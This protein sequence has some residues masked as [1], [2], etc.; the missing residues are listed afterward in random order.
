MRRHPHELKNPLALFVEIPEH[1]DT[2]RI[3]THGSGHFQPMQPILARD[4]GVVDFPAMNRERLSIE[5]KGVA[6]DFKV[7][8]SSVGSHGGEGDL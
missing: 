2:D 5:T 4:A 8:S 6:T 3:Q 1:V 7:M